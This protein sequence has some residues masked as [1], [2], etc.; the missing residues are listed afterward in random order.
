MKVTITSIKLRGPFKLFILSSEAMKIMKQLK[1]TNCKGFKK[2]GWWTKQYTMTLWDSEDELKEFARTG[3][4]LDAMKLSKKISTEIQTITINRQ[5]LLKWK[6]A[7]KI[8]STEGKTIRFE[9]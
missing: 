9:N 2:T 4:H 1:A 6:E 3:A 8:L 5:A 7:K